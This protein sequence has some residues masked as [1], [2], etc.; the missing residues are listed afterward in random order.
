[1]P[2]AAP[3]G[4]ARL[5]EPAGSE[6]GPT[7]TKPAFLAAAD[8]VILYVAGV[9]RFVAVYDI[10][11]VWGDGLLQI[12]TTPPEPPASVIVGNGL[13]VTV[14]VELPV[15]QPL[16]MVVRVYVVV[17]VGFTFT[18]EVVLLPTNEFGIAGSAVH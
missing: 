3:A 13:T 1:M 10:D 7:S 14:T 18:G 2:A 8:H 12:L 16:S 4:I 11:K 6:T 9:E 5:M 15:A 17:V